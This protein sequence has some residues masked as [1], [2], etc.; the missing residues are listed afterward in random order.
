[1]AYHNYLNK[2]MKIIREDTSTD[3]ANGIIVVQKVVGTFMCRLEN[4]SSTEQQ[5]LAR[6]SLETFM[7]IFTTPDADPLVKDLDTVR[8][9]E[10]N[11]TLVGEFEI[12]RPQRMEQT[13][14]LHHLELDAIVHSNTT[15]SLPLI[16]E[17]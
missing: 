16:P 11:G 7:R 5:Y 1:M 12:R 4:L 6:N 3:E 2:I 17:P 9:E 15:A 14:N 10:K 13:Q 8:V